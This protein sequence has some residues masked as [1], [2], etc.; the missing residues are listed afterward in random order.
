MNKERLEWVMS[1]LNQHALT[2]TEDQFVK[3]A[4]EDFEKKHA[5][6]EHQEERLESLYKEKSKLTPN[7]NSSDYFSFKESSP[8]KTKPRKPHWKA[9]F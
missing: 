6:A 4:L 1:G 5:L 9:V 8:K 3:T 2:K 7:K